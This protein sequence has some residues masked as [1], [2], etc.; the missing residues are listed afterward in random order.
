LVA[1]LLGRLV[2][3]MFLIVSGCGLFSSVFLIVSGCFWVWVG[4]VYDLNSFWLSRL[5]GGSFVRRLRKEKLVGT[6]L[7]SI[8]LQAQLRNFVFATFACALGP[9]EC[10]IM[11][12]LWGWREGPSASPLGLAE[13]PSASSLGPVEGPWALRLGA[14]GGPLVSA[15]GL[16][17]GPTF[18]ILNA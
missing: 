17:E 15:L 12:P 5:A 10:H 13:G 8:I 14:A 3:S 6:K 11:F 9:M 7:I 2:S 1:W 4:L 18:V 16:L